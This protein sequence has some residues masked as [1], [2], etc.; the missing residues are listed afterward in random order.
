MDDNIDPDDNCWKGQTLECIVP[1]GLNEEMLVALPQHV[2][3]NSESRGTMTMCT[4][5]KG[6][7]WG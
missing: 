5:T 2:F 6:E 3:L 7:R 4:M 1:L